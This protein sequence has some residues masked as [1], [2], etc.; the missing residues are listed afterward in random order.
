MKEFVLKHSAVAAALLLLFTLAG[1]AGGAESRPNI[2][3]IVVDDMSC[4]FG[5]EGEPL[6]TTPNVDK[7]AREGVV[8]SQAYATAPVCSTFRSAMITG[9]YQTTIGAHHH[10]SSRGELKVSLPAGVRTIPELFREAGYFT[11]ITDASGEKNGKQDYNFDYNPDDLYDGIDWKKHAEGQPFFAQFQLRGGKIRNV[12]QWIEEARADMDPATLVSVD[13]VELPPYYPDHPVIRDDWAA[14]LDSVN[15]TDIEVGRIIDDL[16]KNG[17]LENT[18][19]FFLTDHGISHARGKQFLYEEGVKI[20]FVVWSP[21]H[22]ATPTVRDELIAHIDLGATSLELAGIEIPETMQ[23]RPLFGERAEPRDYVVSARDRC[24]ETVDRIRSIRMGDFKYIRNFH[25]QRPYLQPC[26][27]KDHK[28]FMPVLR[29][30]YAGGKLDDVQSL[31]MAETRPEEELYDLSQD[32]WEIHNLAADPDHQKRLSDFRALLGRW[33]MDSNDQGRF[34]ESEAMFDS[35]MAAYAS[36][37]LKKKD[38]GYFEEVIRNIALMKKW[39]AEG[40]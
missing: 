4:H 11:S 31:I 39:R 33:V 25:P 37:R 29:E 14:Y 13:E 34:P 19:I 21:Q 6:V 32:P 18:I 8:F 35:D 27:Y 40:K 36:S 23:G 7:L 30:L 2:V 9:M 26:A 22:F 16:E 24:D 20:P 10:R 15:Y 5:Y 1:D 17:G 38:P 12:G 3:W 28:P